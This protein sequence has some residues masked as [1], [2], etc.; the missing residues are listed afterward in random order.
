MLSRLCERRTTSGPSFRFEKFSIFRN[1]PLQEFTRFASRAAL[2]VKKARLENYLRLSTI[3]H[4]SIY[5]ARLT[6]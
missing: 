5:E 6:H 4:G 3:Q 2:T 1:L